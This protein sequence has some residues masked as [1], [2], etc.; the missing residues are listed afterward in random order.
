MAVIVIMDADPDHPEDWHILK[1]DEYGGTG[2]G[3]D[4]RTFATAELADVWIQSNA[5]NGWCTTIVG[6]DD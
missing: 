3:F 2:S 6:E 5:K 4:N 1:D